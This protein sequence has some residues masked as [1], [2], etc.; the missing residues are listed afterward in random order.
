MSETWTAQALDAI[1][2]AG[3]RSGGAREAVVEALGAE[4]GCITA[5]ELGHKLHARGRRVGIASVYRAV[6]LLEELGLVQRVALGNGAFNYELVDPD[7]DHHHHVVCRHCGDTLIFEDPKLE[8]A[9]HAIGKRVRY[10]VDSHEVTLHGSCPSCR[11]S[12]AA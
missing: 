1:A 8:A 5:D 4:G 11:D 10:E 6:A 7:G 3:Y 12:D 9:I 2:A